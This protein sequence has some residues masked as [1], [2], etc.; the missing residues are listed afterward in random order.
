LNRLYEKKLRSIGLASLR[1]RRDSLWAL[2]Y[3]SHFSGVLGNL[4]G[5]TLC[6]C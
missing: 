6:L 2:I 3:H 4:V 5:P 1:E